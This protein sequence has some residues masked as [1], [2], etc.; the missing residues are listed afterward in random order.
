MKRSIAETQKESMATK[1]NNSPRSTV[2]I[3]PERAPQGW[4]EVQQTIAESSGIALLLVEGHQPPALAIANNNSICEALQSSPEHVTLCDPFCGAAHERAVDA[5]AI[6]HYRCHAGLQCFAMPIEID[7]SRKLAVIGG[8]AFVSSSHY[9]ELAERFRSGDLMSLGSADLFRNVIFADE[10]DL[11]HAALQLSRAAKEIE[12]IRVEGHVTS[13][14]NTLVDSENAVPL[15]EAAA[16][17]EG[18]QAE[19]RRSG[20]H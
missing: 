5:N 7:S 10:A 4:A 18:D 14:E 17:T 9:R 16:M 8:R 11:D 15:T 2:Q 20:G 13:E 12:A 19:D 1:E 3:V 6:T